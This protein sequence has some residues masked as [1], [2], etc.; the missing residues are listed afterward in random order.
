MRLRTLAE[1][2]AVL[3][4]FIAVI[5]WIFL[6]FI[7]LGPPVPEGDA[8]QSIG[9]G[10]FYQEPLPALK[11]VTLRVDE[12][13]V[14]LTSRYRYTADARV[15]AKKEY[16]PLGHDRI[17]PMD[18]GLATGD[19][20]KDEYLAAVHYANIN[21]MLTFMIYSSARVPPLLPFYLN[22]HV[23]NN[24][25]VFSNDTVHHAAQ[26]LKYG[27]CARITGY[28]VDISAARSDGSVWTM[29]TST[30]REDRFAGACEVIYVESVRTATC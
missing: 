23:S 10:G 21:R 13:T 5:A 22:E 18:L 24:H 17:A 27:D 20:K 25:L 6:P 12:Y 14:T 26:Q 16:L 30:S 4:P 2:A 11:V 29:R 7:P 8:L 19:L 15:V 28:L 1:W 3:V 9:E